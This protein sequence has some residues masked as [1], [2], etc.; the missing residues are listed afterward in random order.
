MY[1]ILCSFS[2][3]KQKPNTTTLPSSQENKIKLPLPQIK[4]INE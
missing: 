1:P 2:T 4:N 3:N